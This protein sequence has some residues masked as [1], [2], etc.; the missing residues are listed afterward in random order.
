MPFLLQRLLRA[1]MGACALTLAPA[2]APPPAVTPG[3][4]DA[5]PVEAPTQLEPRAWTAESPAGDVVAWLRRGC[6]RAAEGKAACVERGLVALLEQAGVA[7]TMEVLDSLAQSDVEVR[8]DG[9][10]LAHGLGMSAYRS[11]AT[12][13]AT[14]AACPP[15]QMSGCQHG[16]IQGYFLEL[17]GQGREPGAV[18][19]DALCAPHQAVPFTYYQ[20]AHGIGHGLMAA[21]G[22][23][24]PSALAG[25]DRASDPDVRRTCHGGAFMENIIQVTHPHHATEG[26][27]RTQGHGAHAQ[28]A[29]ADA[30]AGHGA[31]RGAWKALDP[32][33]P[34]YPC[35]AVDARYGDACY[36]LQPSAVMF[37]AGGDVERTA[38]ACQDAPREFAATCFMSLGREF[39]AWAVQDHVR[40]LDA[41]RRAGEASEARAR[42]WCEQGALRTLMSQAADPQEGIRFCRAVQGADA[43]RDCYRV[44]GE[45]VSMLA[46]GTQ[47]RGSH[48]RTAEPE[49]IATCRRGAG[50][51]PSDSRD[52]E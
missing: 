44:V 5:P 31:E 8:A 50:I 11:P 1:C 33:D 13:A 3:P 29:S 2:C 15:S 35:N 32:A 28:H 25:C 51:D 43:K 40:T 52:E 16:V 42:A 20:C 12:L 47:A 30:H 38:R 26:H 22:N 41:C 27:A 14:F 23:H 45:F 37:F 46:A 34:Q 7:R 17:A 36:D 49:F 18:E 10:A 4:I 9:H 24:L 48:C 19:L 6:E 39:T 21:Y